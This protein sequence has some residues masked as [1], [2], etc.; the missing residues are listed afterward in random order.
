LGRQCPDGKIRG[1]NL[2]GWLVLE[3]W[4]LPQLFDEFHQQYNG[5]IH[6]EWTLA[7]N[8][9]EPDYRSRMS[10]HWDE[11][12]S[13]EELETLSDSGINYIRIPVGYWTWQVAPG[14]PFPKP[15]LDDTDT[16][17]ALYYLKR[18]LVWLDQLGM[19]ANIDLHGAPGSQNGFDNSGRAGEA[20]WVKEGQVE[21][22]KEVLRMISVTVRGWVEE[23]VISETTIYTW[24]VLN[25]PAGWQTEIW[26]ACKDDYYPASYNVIRELWPQTTNVN[27]QQ[28]FRAGY[29]F[30]NLMVAHEFE[31]VSVDMHTYQCFGDFWNAVHND[32]A[33]KGLHYDVSCAYAYE[34]RDRYHW[35]FSGEWSLGNGGPWDWTDPTYVEFLRLW[36]L[37]QMDAYEYSEKG[38]GWFFWSAKIQ[39]DSSKEWNYLSLLEN[40]VAP[41]DLCSRETFCI[42]EEDQQGNL[43]S[44]S[45][46]ATMAKDSFQKNENVLI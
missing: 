31:N 46:N 29:E 22:T 12:I 25:E 11:W 13:R 38:A 7:E 45:Y 37:A 19:K 23:G 5:D 36:L 21:R 34:V 15:I 39:G 24:C 27:I 16:L 20:N 17:G 10:R 44:T 40:G 6:D 14:E 4:M 33:G 18:L 8:V 43:I 26:D 30:D 2:G 28:A 32:D 41:A 1:V 35:I 3:E 9:P 42:L